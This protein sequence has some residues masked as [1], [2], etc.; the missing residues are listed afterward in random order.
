MSTSLSSRSSA[1]AHATRQQLDELD[2]LLQRMLELPVHKIDEEPEPIEPPPPVKEPRPTR[3]ARPMVSYS[4]ETV[5]VPPAAKEP[6]LPSLEPRVV[7]RAIPEE[8]ARSAEPN[9]TDQEDAPADGESWVP[10][11]SSWEPSSLTWQPL[12]E[13]WKQI[14]AELR[15][16]EEEEAEPPRPNFHPQPARP[17]WVPPAPTIT[18]PQPEP[19]QEDDDWVP[20]TPLSPAPKSITHSIPGEEPVADEKPATAPRE[21]GTSWWQ[22][23]LVA[24]NVVFDLFL[25]PLGPLGGWLSRRSGRKFLGG[26]GLLA[27]AAAVGLALADWIGWTW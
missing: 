18:P 17:E 21:K 15:R 16:R 3:V 20:M 11:K 8:S 2:A 22:M 5:D 13:N 19:E 23:P 4:D 10:F 27:L 24:F 12:Q 6:A 14:Q 9:T 7:R 1:P 26:I 25:L